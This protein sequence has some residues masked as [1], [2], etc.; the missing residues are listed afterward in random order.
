MSKFYV[1]SKLEHNVE[2]IISVE[3]ID[4]GIQ[5]LLFRSMNDNWSEDVKGELLIK[6][7]SDGNGYKINHK[8]REKKHLDYDEA[9]HLSLLLQ[10]IGRQ[11]NNLTLFD[12]MQYE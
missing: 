6:V 2:Y 10:F 1:I 7:I 12:V 4:E 5:Y 8:T 3:L 9:V 11:E